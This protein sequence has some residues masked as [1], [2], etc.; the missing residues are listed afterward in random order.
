[1]NEAD[2]P[3][4]AMVVMEPGSDWPGPIGDSTTVVMLCQRWALIAV[5]ALGAPAFSASCSVDSN[6]SVESGDAGAKGATSSG[7]GSAG[8]SGSGWNLKQKL[9]RGLWP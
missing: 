1:M 7:D 2:M 5:I 8:S 3:T 9:P 6:G 4:T